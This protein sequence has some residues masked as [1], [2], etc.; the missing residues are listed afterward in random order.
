MFSILLTFALFRWLPLTHSDSATQALR[1]TSC[2]RRRRPVEAFLPDITCAYVSADVWWLC[3][4]NVSHADF[5]DCPID[6]LTGAAVLLPALTDL[7]LSRRPQ[8]HTY[9]CNLCALSTRFLFSRPRVL[10]CRASVQVDCGEVLCIGCAES[11]IEQE[12]AGL[13]SITAA[14][15]SRVW[16]HSGMRFAGPRGRRCAYP[17][18]LANTQRKRNCRPWYRLAQK[19]WCPSGMGEVSFASRSTTLHCMRMPATSQQTPAP[20]A[21]QARPRSRTAPARHMQQPDELQ[22]M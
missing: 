10:Q 12:S 11:R 4:A 2:D 22:T 3:R 17:P 13:C 6:G 5:H 15:Y 14:G 20:S 21:S 1:H 19:N 8:S 9:S 16:L 18:A 7:R